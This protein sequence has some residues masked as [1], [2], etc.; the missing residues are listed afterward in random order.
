MVQCPCKVC[1]FATLTGA[2]LRL[3]HAC[4]SSSMRYRTWANRATLPKAVSS[5]RDLQVLGT[6]RTALAQGYVQVDEFTW[7]QRSFM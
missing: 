3:E 7:A 5:L 1:G 2:K 4:P 6:G